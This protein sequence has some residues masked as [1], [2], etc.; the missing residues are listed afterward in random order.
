[1]QFKL[2]L[3]F[4][5]CEVDGGELATVH[6]RTPQLQPSFSE[7]SFQGRRNRGGRDSPGP[8]NFCSRIYDFSLCF[9]HCA[10]CRSAVDMGHRVQRRSGVVGRCPRPSHEK[11]KHNFMRNNAKCAKNA[12]LVFNF[13]KISG[14]GPPAPP[15]LLR[16]FG[17]AAPLL[18]RCDGS[19]YTINP[20]L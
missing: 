7:A 4:Y 16:A 11:R 3:I 9:V 17:R 1:M 18:W 15:P 19:V 14:G 8:P 12:R 20:C 2:N 10:T 13:Q 6:L 5:Y